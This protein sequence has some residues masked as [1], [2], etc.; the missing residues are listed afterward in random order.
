MTKQPF[1]MMKT[2]GAVALITMTLLN[3]TNFQLNYPR[4]NA[5]IVTLMMLVLGFQSYS[6]KKKFNSDIAFVTIAGLAT[7]YIFFVN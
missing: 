3:Y 7:L 1:R 4:Y 2:V 6:E 5:L